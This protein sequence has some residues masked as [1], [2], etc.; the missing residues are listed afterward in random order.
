LPCRLRFAR[1]SLGRLS[2]VYVYGSHRSRVSLVV[3]IVELIEIVVVGQ[4][5]TTEFLVDRI[6]MLH[7]L[8]KLPDL[9]V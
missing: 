1:C 3:A 9:L 6:A 7:S 5:I 8:E 4:W 2:E